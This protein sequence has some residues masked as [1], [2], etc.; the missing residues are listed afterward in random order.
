M[1]RPQHGNLVTTRTQLP[2]LE[3]TR[4]L[5]AEIAVSLQIA[6]FLAED[7]SAAIRQL[8]EAAC[9]LCNAGSAGVSLLHLNSDGETMVR[10]DAISGVLASQE[11][12]TMPVSASSC[13]LCFDAGTTI[14]VA[15]PER[16][17]GDPRD[18]PQ[19]DEE[20]IVPLYGNAKTPRGTLWLVRHDDA[21]SFCSD[22][23]RIAEQLAVQ[24]RA[25]LRL[26]EQADEQRYAAA[27]LESHQLAERRL[28][29]HDLAEEHRLRELA[30]ASEHALRQA[31][32]FRDAVIRDM[33]HR[34]KNTLQVA[35][36][37]LAQ[38]AHATDSTQA[39]VALLE[40]HD[41]LHV[42]A[43]VHE[44]LCSGRDST[45]AVFMPTLLQ[46]IGGAVRQAFESI[47]PRVA[48]RVTAEPIELPAEDAIAL[49]LLVNEALT[50]ACKHAF[51]DAAAGE[52][53]VS[54]RGAPD[55]TL[56]LEVVDTGVG[57][58]STKSHLGFGL[59]LM[60]TFAAQLHGTLTIAGGAA[61]AGTALTVT[62]R[63]DAHDAAALAHPIETRNPQAAADLTLS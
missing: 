61:G 50:N 8:L 39:R 43:K 2:K 9:R 12:R 5:Q 7:P 52:V 26:L 44:Q 57:M 47:G 32:T 38:H 60:R 4:D 18:M 35:A 6:G 27:I 41:R 16:K 45:H 56:I 53:T 51:P 29:Y 21:G 10:W 37:L 28:L 62:I 42:L 31:V 13:G 22:D 63:R 14:V 49:A 48:L 59:K 11:G 1:D 55:N 34:V 30:E 17:S 19:V 58:R 23:A 46:A 20:L 25:A 54:L 33:N 36:V 15:R 40:S 3:R 24:L